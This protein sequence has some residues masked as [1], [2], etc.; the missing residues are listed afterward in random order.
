[1]C[2]F[3]SPV[4]RLLIQSNSFFIGSTDRETL[5]DVS[6]LHIPSDRFSP[7]RRSSDGITLINKYKSQLEKMYNQAVKND[8]SQ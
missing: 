6:A 5:K 7:V 8:V 1:M 2:K 4:Y 3:T